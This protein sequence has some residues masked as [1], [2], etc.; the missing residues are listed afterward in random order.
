MESSEKMCRMPGALC[1]SFTYAFPHSEKGCAPVDD[2]TKKVVGIVGDD[3]LTSRVLG[4]LLEG[5]GYE[6][7]ALQAS[8]VLEHPSASLSGVDLVLFMPLLSDERNYELLDAMKGTPQTALVPVLRLSTEPKAER[9]T[10]VLPWPW[11]TEALV[12][13]IEQALHAPGV[14]EAP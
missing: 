12:G 6:V 8:A 1:P 10:S 13:A 11:S 3:P 7:R 4:M 9:T 14:D 5:A 2:A